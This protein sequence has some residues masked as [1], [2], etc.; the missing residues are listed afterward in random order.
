MFNRFDLPVCYGQLD[1]QPRGVMAEEQPSTSGGAHPD[2][3]LIV[4]NVC[5]RFE[6][7]EP[8]NIL[9]P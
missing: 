7:S 6:V 5:I 1:Q 3:Y 8:I 2:C 9:P 4:Y